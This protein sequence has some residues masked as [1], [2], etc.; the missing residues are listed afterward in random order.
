MLQSSLPCVWGT[1][2]GWLEVAGRER[3]SPT[4]ATRRFA[5]GDSSS[6]SSSE[7]PQ[8]DPC[9][10]AASWVRPGARVHEPAHILL[11]RIER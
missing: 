11:M 10:A 1:Q 9:P 8:L 4:P 2:P 6:I 5:L 3:S 7:I